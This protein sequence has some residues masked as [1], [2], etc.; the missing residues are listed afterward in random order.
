MAHIQYMYGS[1]GA[2]VAVP[3]LIVK[4]NSYR[5]DVSS[6][7]LIYTGRGRVTIAVIAAADTKVKLQFCSVRFG[8]VED[9]FC[10]RIRK[11]RMSSSSYLPIN[12]C[13]RPATQPLSPSASPSRSDTFSVVCCS[14]LLIPPARAT[15]SCDCLSQSMRL[16][17]KAYIPAS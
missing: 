8:L 11:V 15:A 5:A 14:A 12:E 16:T 6:G 4:C 2:E 3:S 7:W 17:R 13:L 10:R 1:S 9:A